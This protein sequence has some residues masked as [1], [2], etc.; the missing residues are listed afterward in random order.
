MAADRIRDLEAALRRERDRSS[1]LER[2]CALLEAARC[3]TARLLA[4]GARPLGDLRAQGARPHA[5]I[6]PH[7]MPLAGLTEGAGGDRLALARPEARSR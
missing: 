7:Q 1:A 5:D 4:S 2:R 3:I 6:H